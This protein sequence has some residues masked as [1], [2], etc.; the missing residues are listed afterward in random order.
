M[1]INI[2]V[3]FIGITILIIL[4]LTIFLMYKLIINSK[5]DNSNIVN[6]NSMSTYDPAT[7]SKAYVLVNSNSNTIQKMQ[8]HQ[9]LNQVN[10]P[11]DFGDNSTILANMMNNK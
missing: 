7:A 4:G 3:A 2:Q 10:S 6:M 9:S 8:N 11:G 1:K 5:K